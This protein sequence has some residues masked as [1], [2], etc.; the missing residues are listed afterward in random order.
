MSAKK[1]AVVVNVRAQKRDG[2]DGFFRGGQKW[3]SGPEGRTAKVSHA[4]L[5]K[6]LQ[7][8]MLTVRY[9]EQVK[10]DLPDDAPVLD[11]PAPAFIDPSQ[12]IL[13]R[14]AV[15][16]AEAKRLAAIEG[17]AKLEAANAE[18]RKALGLPEP[19]A[20]EKSKANQAAASAAAAAEARG[21]VDPS[22]KS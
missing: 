4:L 11:L 6:L 7:D 3:P 1:D 19:T 22:K 15:A 21:K 20:E 16:E 18:K 13:D 14:I 5:E 8:E 17:V 12:A 9:G 10:G 2:F